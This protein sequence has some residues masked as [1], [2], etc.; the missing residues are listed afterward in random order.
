MFKVEEICKR[1]KVSL[2]E[3]KTEL[4][5]ASDYMFL[6][7]VILSAQTTDIQVNKVMS[8][9]FDEYKTIDD[10]LSLGLEQLMQKIRSIGLYKSKAKHIIE[11]SKI[12]KSK[13]H[14]QVPN[15]RKDLESLPGVGRKTA[16]VVMNTLFDEPTIAVDT[17]VQRVSKRLG[18]SQSDDPIKIEMDLEKIIPTIYKKSISNLLIHHGRYTCKAKK[19]D[20]WNCVLADLCNYFEYEFYTDFNLSK[21]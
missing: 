7:A 9:L 4:K 11:A 17:H 6:I 2:K 15:S 1:L 3:P 18:L 12:L 19:L 8:E 21:S 20:C 5:Y 14:S 10:I 16:N 13:F